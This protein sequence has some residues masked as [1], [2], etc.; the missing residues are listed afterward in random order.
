MNIR[1]IKTLQELE[2][3]QT[4]WESW[5]NH[6][7]NDFAQFKLVCQL[8]PEIESPYVL[9]IERNNQPHA[10]LAGRSEWTQFA[11]AIGYLKPVRIPS[12]VIAVIHQGLL[13]HWDEETARE[14]VHY[15]WSLLGAGVADAI[16]F[17]HLS[18]H[19]IL[20]QALQVHISPWFCEKKPRWSYH[21]QMDIPVEGGFIK[22]KM[23]S[24]HRSEI[25]KM[26]RE[27]ESA[28]PGKVSWRW[29]SQF[30]DV[31]GL[32][33]Q[34][35]E[36]AASTYQRGLGSGFFNN[37]EFRQRLA[38]F[39]WR[40]LLRVQFLDI[41]GKAQA[42]WFGTVY[43]GVFYLS[44]TSYDPDLRRYEVGTLT[45][46]R[47]VDELAQEEG[48]LKLDF[49]LGDAHYKQRFGDQSWQETTICLFAPTAKG[50]ALRSM[51]RLSIILDSAARQ[52]LQKMKLTDRLKT[53]W[54]RRVAKGG[55]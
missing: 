41:D 1:I 11:P 3:V 2:T 54:R 20:L 40:G 31:P 51:L 19:S 17:H 32:C 15:L 42:F 46:I 8:R 49:S 22:N 21:W 52:V 4:Y 50:L 53:I 45:F 24:K 38:L 9:V 48:V 28:F 43:Q 5:Q 18:E 26:Q 12:K 14:S 34:L 25:R 37:E 23:R 47:M 36:V 6:A 27:L 44:E 7:N 33:A 55:N 29:M 35:E 30:D 10:L 39:A 13:G 16:E